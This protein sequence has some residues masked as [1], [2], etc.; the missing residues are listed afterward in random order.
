MADPLCVGASRNPG[1]PRPAHV[2]TI[3]IAVK[4]MLAFRGAENIVYSGESELADCKHTFLEEV[5]K[6]ETIGN[7]ELRFGDRK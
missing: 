3:T 6:A 4:A 1:V 2:I 7:K 5:L